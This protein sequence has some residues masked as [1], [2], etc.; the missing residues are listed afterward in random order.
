MVYWWFGQY[1]PVAFSLLIKDTN[2][3]N[4]IYSTI[5]ITFKL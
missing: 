4:F 2:Y 5:L 3:G 1:A